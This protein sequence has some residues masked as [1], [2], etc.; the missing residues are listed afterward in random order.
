MVISACIGTRTEAEATAIAAD[1]GFVDALAACWPTVQEA[2]A[3]NKD[4]VSTIASIE[5]VCEW[6]ERAG[7]VF[8]RLG[9]CI[10]A[11][12]QP[13][14]SD[15][16]AARADFLDSVIAYDRVIALMQQLCTYEASPA[17]ISD[18]AKKASTAFNSAMAHVHVYDQS[19][20]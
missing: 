13:R 3:F 5:D 9:N 4:Q 16:I 12:P 1:N 20:E 2:V 17:E 8:E 19:I 15:L 14:D 6:P 10:E 11:L 7:P 18:W